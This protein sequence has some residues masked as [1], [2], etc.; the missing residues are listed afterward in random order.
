ST[1]TFWFD[2]WVKGVRLVREFP[3]IAAATQF[4]DE[5]VSNVI[6]FSDRQRCHI[7]LRYQLRGGALEEWYKLILHLA[8]IPRDRFSEGPASI[9]WTPSPDGRFTVSSLRGLLVAEFTG[10]IGFP[11]DTIWQSLVPSKIACHAWK[12]YHKKMATIDNLQQKGFALANRCV[13]CGNNLESVDHLF[14]SCAFTSEVWT[15][16]SSKLSIH[17]PL[18]SS[19]VDF[20]QSWKGLN[21]STRFVLAKEVLLHAVF[22]FIWK[23]R[24]DRIFHDRTSSV[25]P[26]LL[27]IWFSVGDWLI[28]HGR[29]LTA[30]LVMWRRLVFDNG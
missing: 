18:S 29:F 13:L 20:I 26:T 19:V 11:A 1:L 3:R 22:W 23:E 7:P 8:A 17:G 10:I 6:T 24:N 5:S 9:S 2:F 28:A 25:F 4:L 27:K 21:C 12:V 16:I 14:L 15:L 30:D